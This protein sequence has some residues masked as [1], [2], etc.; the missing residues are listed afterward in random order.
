[1]SFT[2][3]DI[4]EQTL[5]KPV[6]A[7]TDTELVSYLK[8]AVKAL[9]DIDLPVDGMPERSVMAGLKRT[10][11]P[12]AGN[13]LKWVCWRHEGKYR[14]QVIGY[15]SFAKGRKWFTDMLYTE[16]QQHLSAEAAQVAAERRAGDGWGELADL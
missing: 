3:L 14:G 6:T 12:Q 5:G 2:D 9:Q 13:I 8:I 11:G 15:F 1:M 16:L 4:A 7:M 10:Y